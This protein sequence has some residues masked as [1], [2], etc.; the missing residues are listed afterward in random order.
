MDNYSG[1][2]IVYF[3]SSQIGADICGFFQDTTSELCDRW[4]ALGAFYPF[5][6]NHNGKGFMVNMHGFLK[7]AFVIMY[8]RKYRLA[9]SSI[10]ISFFKLMNIDYV[11]ISAGR[12]SKLF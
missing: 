10:G 11:L 1:V 8:G 12:I 7:N 2:I 6:R 4:M 5:S 9:Q 3:S